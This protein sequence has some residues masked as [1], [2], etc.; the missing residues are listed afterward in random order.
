MR[1]WLLIGLVF[2]AFVPVWGADPAIEDDLD[3]SDA[4]LS[5]EVSYPDW[6]KLSFLNLPEDLEEAIDGG[7]KGLIVY[8][9]QKHC[10]YCKALMVR[11]FGRPDIAAYTQRNFD[12]VA[13][14]IW[15]DR[16][17]TDMQQHILPEKEL[18]VREQTNFTPSLIFYDAD[19]REALRLRG[20][21]PPYKFL[22][23][24]E[25]VAEG[26]H[27]DSTFR[28]YLD[29]GASALSFDE[30][31]LND[32]QLFAPGPVVLQRDP[33]YGERPLA[34]FYEQP[35]CHACDLLHTGPLSDPEIVRLIGRM[36]TAQLNMNGTEPVI[37]PEGER[38]T[39]Q[40]WARRLG[41]FHAPTVLFFDEWGIEILRIDSVVQ[42]YRLR[43]VLQYVLSED[44][45]FEPN[46]QRWRE[47][48]KLTQA[49]DQDG[50]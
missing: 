28:D 50:G 5:D 40:E 43:S 49:T 4:P 34:V 20:Y 30:G 44:Y 33:I 11:G 32:S 35:L 16:M 47:R 26:R 23:A 6:F 41:L 8:F 31:G 21:Y 12:V 2:A 48:S 45:L 14:D 38:L 42:L 29:R 36:D 17:V 19:G 13:L 39:A 37:T 24:L 25:Y 18:A 9:G 3:F 46:F 7:K 27:R 1:F 10:A 22:A 15:S